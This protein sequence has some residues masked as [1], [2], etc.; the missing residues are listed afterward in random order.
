MQKNLKINKC[1]GRVLG[2]WNDQLEQS[3]NQNDIPPMQLSTA[4][5]VNHIVSNNAL[6]QPAIMQQN[7]QQPQVQRNSFFLKWRAGSTVSKW[8]GCHTKI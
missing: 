5:P 6:Y 3:L 2:L 8:H 7:Y 4:H 1:G